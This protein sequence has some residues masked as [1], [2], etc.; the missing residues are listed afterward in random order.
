MTVPVPWAALILIAAAYRIWRLL[1]EDTILTRPRRWLT[2]LPADW[3]EDDPIPD[4]Y[5]IGLANFI[6]CP[7]CFGFW[8]ALAIWLIWEVT[9]FWTEVFSMPLAISAGLIVFRSKL[10]PPD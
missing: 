7:A 1:A 9:P 8:I 6:S 2:N 10:D 5:R 4:D 3:E